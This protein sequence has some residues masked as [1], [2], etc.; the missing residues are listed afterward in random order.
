MIAILVTLMMIHIVVP[1]VMT[2]VIPAIIQEIILVD[3]KVI[4][5]VLINTVVVTLP[6]ID[7]MMINMIQGLL[8]TAKVTV[9]NQPPVW[10]GLI[11]TRTIDL[12]IGFQKMYTLNHSPV[13]QGTCMIGV[14]P[15]IIPEIIPLTTNTISQGLFIKLETIGVIAL[16]IQPPIRR[17]RITTLTVNL[18]KPQIMI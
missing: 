3:P 11:T 8:E 9:V 4:L 14:A 7:T 2:E 15:L 6:L 12:L 16:V 18:T 13:R 5:Q 1:Q 10:R 17:G